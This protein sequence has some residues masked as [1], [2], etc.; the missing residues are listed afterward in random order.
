MDQENQF[1]MLDRV[2]AYI[3]ARAQ[4]G[5]KTPPPE[6][7]DALCRDNSLSREEG[8]LALAWLTQNSRELHRTGETPGK[9]LARLNLPV[10]SLAAK[11]PP[12]YRT[13]CKGMRSTLETLKDALEDVAEYSEKVSR[14][15][16]EPGNPPAGSPEQRGIQAMRDDMAALEHA[17]R[18][19]L[20]RLDRIERADRK[21]RPE[22]PG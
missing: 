11:R 14:H 17:A 2:H 20:D 19:W 15:Q 10:M 9:Y 5:S 8:F 7:F 21:D 18:W 22:N 12:E 13:C 3:G 4:A 6:A 16:G 1:P